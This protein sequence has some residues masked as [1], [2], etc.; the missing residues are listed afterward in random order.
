MQNAL[1]FENSHVR[2]VPL[3]IGVKKKFLQRIITKKKYH[4]PLLHWKKISALLVSGKK[5]NLSKGNLP[6]P[7]QKSNGSPLK[8]RCVTYVSAVTFNWLSKRSNCNHVSC[9]MTNI[10]TRDGSED[11]R[12]VSKRFHSCFRNDKKLEKDPRGS[13]TKGR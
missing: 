9:N 3:L 1:Y 7:P 10:N 12:A 13:K 6:T 8:S 2:P 11:L 5:N 4:G